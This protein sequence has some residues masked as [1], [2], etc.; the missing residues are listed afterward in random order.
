MRGSDAHR[1]HCRRRTLGLGGIATN[2]SGRSTRRRATG[3]AGSAPKPTFVP[4]ATRPWAWAAFPPI[5]ARPPGS[6]G[7]PCTTFTFS[8]S[9]RRPP[10]APCPTCSTP[11][12]SIMGRALFLVFSL[13]LLLLLPMKKNQPPP[14]PPAPSSMS[15]AP[16]GRCICRPFTFYWPLGTGGCPWREITRARRGTR[17]ALATHHHPH[18]QHQHHHQHLHLH[19]HQHPH[20][21]H[22]YRGGARFSPVRNNGPPRGR[23]RCW[24]ACAHAIGRNGW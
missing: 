19:L 23:A 5:P 24:W 6:R 16:I 14:P 15:G 7:R 9:S 22:H 21:Q 10:S 8:A 18:H 3:I 1:H 20:H 17:Q 13:L 2:A 11:P 4:P 12:S